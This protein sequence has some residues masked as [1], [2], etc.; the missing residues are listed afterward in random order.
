MADLT[1][2]LV[3]ALSDGSPASHVLL[4]QKYKLC[5][6]SFRKKYGQ[7]AAASNAAFFIGISPR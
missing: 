7:F 4:D 1:D 2:S 5:Y 6:A 3:Q